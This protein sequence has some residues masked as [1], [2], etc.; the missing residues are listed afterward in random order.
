MKCWEADGVGSGGVITSTIRS[1]RFFRDATHFFCGFARH[2]NVTL[3]Y[4]S[5]LIL[6]NKQFSI[7]DAEF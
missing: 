6:T 5:A 4:F 1:A 3:L 7:F 2:F